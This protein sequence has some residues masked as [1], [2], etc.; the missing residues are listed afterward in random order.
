[1]KS[2]PIQ[3]RLST[4]LASDVVGYSRLIGLD[5]A[6]TVS[7]VKAQITEVFEPKA[8]QYRGRIVK[9]M[10]DG[11]LM[12]FSSIADA[13]MFAVEIQL[14]LKEQ[15][16]STPDDRKLI[17]RIGINIGEIIVD[18]DDIQGAGVNIAAR[19][20]SIAEPGGVFLSEAAFGQVQGK[21]DLNFEDM[22]TFQVKNIAD[23]VA[24]TKVLFDDRADHMRTAIIPREKRKRPLVQK[25][26]ITAVAFVLLLSGGAGLYWSL[27]GSST[28]SSTPAIAALEIPK[29]PSIAV[30]PFK[31]IGGSADVE[32]FSDGLTGDLIADLSKFNGL[33]VS[34]R[35]SAYSYKD[36]TIPLKQ[37]GRELGVRYILQGSSQ[38]AGEKIRVN[39]DLIEASTGKNL[40]NHRFDG[41]FSD[42]FAV[43]DEIIRQTV[44]ALTVKL[45]E[46]EL[47]RSKSVR[48]AQMNAYDYVLR[49]REQNNQGTRSGNIESR[50][51]LQA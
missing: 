13:I 10:G 32:Y 28:P 50:K 49:G 12:E 1:M 20:E 35:N 38:Q 7:A 42:I 14:I 2:K 23:P 24:V 26:A 37:I 46:N 25:F 4:I 17:H 51:L 16:S 27:G 45:D 40:W 33:F 48:P 39:V 6:G 41:D 29:K 34:A 8:A 43:Q 44:T 31:N 15:N 47:R 30:L 3:R 5:E 11:V 9:L 21:L 18:G 22:G 19:I 36:T